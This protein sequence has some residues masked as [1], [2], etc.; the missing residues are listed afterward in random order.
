MDEWLEIFERNFTAQGGQVH[1]AENAQQAQE[2]VLEIASQNNAKLA[3]KV[4]SMATEEIALNHCLEMNGIDVF[5]TDL[6]EFIIQL[7]GVGPSHIITPAVHMKKEEI[8]ALFWQKLGVD[9]PEDPIKLTQI[10]RD[11]L[12][13]KFLK[14]DLGIS[15]PILW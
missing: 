9:A 10:A 7:A 1:W 8:A 6:G 15:E 5:E 14:A 12:R 2:I 3:V 13:E 4:K 11:V